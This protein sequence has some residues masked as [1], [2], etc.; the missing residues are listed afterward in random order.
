MN[1][2][3]VDAPPTTIEIQG[4]E[5]EINSDFRS[6]LKIILAFEDPDLAMVEKSAV[7]VELLYKEPPENLRE[8]IEKG[9]E[10]LNGGGSQKMEDAGSRVFSFQKDSRLIMAGFRQTYQIDLQDFDLHWWTFITL[11]MDL[12]PDTTF[13]NLVSF[14]QRVSKG[15]ATVDEKKLARELGDVFQ[16]D[17][18]IFK[19]LEM[20][21]AE[22]IFFDALEGGG[23]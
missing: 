20:L 3:L 18:V 19:D 6:C 15:I 12:S 17:N 11:F 21:E 22:K 1:N 4:R 9:V 2:I 10:F 23:Q 14:R 8:A 16:L 5:C 7:L 13:S